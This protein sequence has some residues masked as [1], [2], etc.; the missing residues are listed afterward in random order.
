M[1]SIATWAH[2][3]S[4]SFIICLWL[5]WIYL[6]LV[7]NPDSFLFLFSF[8]SPSAQFELLYI[9]ILF[10]CIIFFRGWIGFLAG[11][12][13]RNRFRINK[14]VVRVNSLDGHLFVT[15]CCYTIPQRV[16][17]ITW[18][19]EWIMNDGVSSIGMTPLPSITTNDYRS[20]QRLLLL[21]PP[22][23][24]SFFFCVIYKRNV[25]CYLVTASYRRKKKRQSRRRGDGAGNF[26]E[27]ADKWAEAEPSSSYI[28]YCCGCCGCCRCWAARY[29]MME[30]TLTN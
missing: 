25:H 3:R 8:F 20:I 12:E 30:W 27:E 10:S 21:F 15:S 29:T 1:W 28:L 22:P 13:R 2:L 18:C 5:L 23:V 24:S 11:R 4:V 7:K 14:Y 17:H 19:L 16:S 9:V 6:E 26:V